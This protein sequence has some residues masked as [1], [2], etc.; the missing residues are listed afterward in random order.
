[1][2]FNNDTTFVDQGR[3][4][5]IKRKKHRDQEPGHEMFWLY[6]YDFYL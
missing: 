3:K 5:N 1:M 6:D 4:V 2:Y